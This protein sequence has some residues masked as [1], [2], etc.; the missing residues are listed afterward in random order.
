V[1]DPTTL[2]ERHVPILRYDSQEPYFADAAMIW[3]LNPGNELRRADGT[4]LATAN[5]GTL[6]LDMLA[7]GAYPGQSKDD[8]VVDTTAHGA[9]TY[10]PQAAALHAESGL[11]NCVYGHVA[12]GSDERTW[13]AYWC[14]YFY[15]DFNLLGPFLHA[16]DHEGDWEMIQLRLDPASETPDLAVFAQHTHAE[17][18][19][20]TGVQ[21]EGDRPV[22]YPARG[23]HASYFAPGTH[24]TGAWFD[25]ADGTHPGPPLRLHVLGEGDGWATWPGYWGGTVKAADDLNPLDDSSPR[26]PGRHAQ[27]ADPVKLLETARG[28]AAQLA[29]RPAPAAPPPPAQV[30][31]T[32]HGDALHISFDPAGAPPSGVVVATGAAGAPRTVHRAEVVAGSAE[33]TIPGA[34]IAPGDTVHVSLVGPGAGGRPEAT[35]ALGVTVGGP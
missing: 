34:A 4:V 1:T 13:L 21:R 30:Q 10:P 8:R 17:E 31:A 20:W 2:L 28:H 5:G 18:R 29:A 23:S 14:F 19:P 7:P 33:V 27:W 25:H 3:M 24:W 11:A 12:T 9:G 16:G 35:P 26:G 22:V 15:N 6:T 32:A